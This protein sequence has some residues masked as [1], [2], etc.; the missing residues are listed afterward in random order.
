MADDYPLPVSLDA[1]LFDAGGVLVDLDYRYLKRLVEPVRR[2]VTEEQ[3]S[4][5]EAQ[6]R[7]EINNTIRDHGRLDE[8]WRDYFHIILGRVGVAGDRHGALIDSLWEAHE[9]VGLW[10]VACGGALDAVALLKKRG[11]RMSLLSTD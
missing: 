10:T 4:A 5:A 7:R 1:V 6:A 3:L 11:I 9:R 8:V 2:D